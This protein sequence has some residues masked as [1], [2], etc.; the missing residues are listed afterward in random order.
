MPDETN[1][2]D[3]VVCPKCEYRH[4]DSYEFFS[5]RSGS[6]EEIEVECRRCE[7]PLIVIREVSVTYLAKLIKK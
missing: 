7:A 2:E 5:N 3:E 1:Y 4:R 6:D